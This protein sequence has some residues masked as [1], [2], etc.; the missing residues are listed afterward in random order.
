VHCVNAEGLWALV[1]ERIGFSAPG[2]PAGAENTHE[3]LQGAGVDR[4]RGALP[5]FADRC[6]L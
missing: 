3:L 2:E 6:D 1:R 5:F 4:T